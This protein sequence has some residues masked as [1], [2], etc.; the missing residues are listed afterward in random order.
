MYLFSL[1]SRQEIGFFP[2]YKHLFDLNHMILYLLCQHSLTYFLSKDINPL[3]E[4]L[5]YQFLS[6][7]LELCCFLFFI[8]NLLFLCYFLYFYH[9][10]FIGF[11]SSF[12]LFSALSLLT[13]FLLLSSSLLPFTFATLV[14]SALASST[15]YIS[16]NISSSSLLLFSD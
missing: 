5:K 2:W 10:F 9:S 3:I 14:F 8:L 7:Y 11:F 16:L 15:F 6:L 4:L 13:S 12:L 1:F